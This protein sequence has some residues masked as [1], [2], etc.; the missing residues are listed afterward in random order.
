MDHVEE[1]NVT[2]HVYTRH[3][4]LVHAHVQFF[5]KGIGMYIMYIGKRILCAHNS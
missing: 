5:F 4:R 1:I 3:T 2:L